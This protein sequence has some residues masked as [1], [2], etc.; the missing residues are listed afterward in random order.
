MWHD[1]TKGD[2]KNC[3]IKRYAL[4]YVDGDEQR[5]KEFDSL[6]DVAKHVSEVLEKWDLDY[7]HEE[8]EEC[9]MLLDMD[10]KCI[11]PFRIAET[12]IVSLIQVK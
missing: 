4:F 10:T 2:Q 12:T 11:I 8:Y 3:I 7:R 9:F 1:E 5:L 6:D